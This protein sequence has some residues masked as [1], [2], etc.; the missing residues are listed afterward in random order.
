MAG[1]AAIKSVNQ[2]MDKLLPEQHSHTRNRE[3]EKGHSR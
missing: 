3:R 1:I 2:V